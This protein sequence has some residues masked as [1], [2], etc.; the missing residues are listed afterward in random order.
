LIQASE[1]EIHKAMLF[2]LR[3]RIATPD[4]LEM[5]LR[6]V[7]AD[8]QTGKIRCIAFGILYRLVQVDSIWSLKMKDGS[9]FAT[10]FIV[11]CCRA[12]ENET[13][14]DSNNRHTERSCECAGIASNT[15]NRAI[16]M[17]KDKPAKVIK[18]VH[19]FNWAQILSKTKPN[20]FETEAYK[21]FVGLYD[22]C[23]DILKENADH[24]LARKFLQ[25]LEMCHDFFCGA[26]EHVVRLTRSLPS[27]PKKKLADCFLI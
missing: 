23:M 19:S 6:M 8:I 3:K 1:E 12:L 4:N 22:F 5:L 11:A 10:S 17:T 26:V 15:L 13:N 2:L 27:V 7:D 21:W 9:Y 20:E 16:V 25:K 24:S 14:E 18:R